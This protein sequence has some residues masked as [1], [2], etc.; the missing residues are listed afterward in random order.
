LANY[1][2]S[3]SRPVSD[4]EPRVILLIMQANSVALISI[5]EV[6]SDADADSDPDWI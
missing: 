1:E 4:L 3:V 5:F 2:L 6:E